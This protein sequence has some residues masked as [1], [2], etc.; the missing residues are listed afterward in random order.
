MRL[1][2]LFL[3]SWAT[4]LVQSDA[5][6]DQLQVEED[7]NLTARA[8]P[9]TNGVHWTIHS[10]CRTDDQGQPDN[11]MRDAIIQAVNDAKDR[12]KLTADRL[13]KWKKDCHSD[14]GNFMIGGENRIIKKACQLL[15]G[16]SKV[17]TFGKTAFQDKV[18]A[19][20]TWYDAVAQ[21]V[22]PVGQA[23][24]QFH[25][26]QEWTALSQKDDHWLNF[27][28]YCGPDLVQRM[29]PSTMVNQLYDQ[30]QLR[31][32]RDDKVHAAMRR[33]YQ[34]DA[35]D[36]EDQFANA[37]TDHNKEELSDFETI[38]GKRVPLADRKHVA[39]TITLHRLMLKKFRDRNFNIKSWDGDLDSALKMGAPGPTDTYAP[40]DHMV[41][42]VGLLHHEM[43]HT[44]GLGM[45][46]DK[47]QSIAYDWKN[48]EKNK[49]SELPEYLMFLALLVELTDK[50]IQ[51]HQDGTLSDRR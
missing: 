20:K 21:I 42:L 6:D 16:D 35:F 23:N 28:I 51:V 25:V 27:I 31:F 18:D 44:P 41:G 7:H 39:A 9:P 14:R 12:S 10:S 2:R 49:D 33:E 37:V 15:L 3:L 36:N 11:A 19:A 29:N 46:S 43:Y 22:G 8:V 45:L 17:T 38:D 1:I 32:V 24:N 26:S 47:D 5:V 48:M 34:A 13:E 30:G 40:I 4:G 50:K